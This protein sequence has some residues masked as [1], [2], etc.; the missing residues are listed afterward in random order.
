[1]KKI[2]SGEIKP[3]KSNWSPTKEGSVV[4][5]AVKSEEKKAGAVIMT[6]EKAPEENLEGLPNLHFQ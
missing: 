6:K 5:E 3:V 4:P 1:M 2:E